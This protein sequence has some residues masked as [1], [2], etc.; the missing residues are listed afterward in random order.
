MKIE[1]PN[2][3]RCGSCSW[4][5]IPYPKQLEQKLS[6]INGSFRLKNLE[7]ECKEIIPA[8]KT[9]H[10]RN[11][12]D[13]VINF[14]GLVGLREKGRWWKVIDNHTCF[15]ADAEIERVFH[16]VRNWVQSGRLSYFDRK[17]HT[18]FL[19]YAV[20]RATSLGQS[21]LNIVSSA[22]ESDQERI[23]LEAFGAN[24]DVSTFIWSVNR[25]IQDISEGEIEQVIKGPG[26]IQE[27][28]LDTQ[29]QISPNAFFQT[30]S[31]AASNLLRTVLE[32]SEALNPNSILDLYCGG[33][34]FSVALAKQL[35]PTANAGPKARR[36]VGVELVEQAIKDARQ[37]ASLNGVD[38]EYHA[39]KTEQFSWASH[40]FELIIL[41]PPRSG[42]HD[43][44]L[45]EIL[46]VQPETI[47]YVSC[48]YKSLARELVQLKEVYSV[49]S[50][51]A[52]DMF[53][54]TPH[55]E[56]VAL[57]RKK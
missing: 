47:I 17:K 18:G 51:K 48:N 42:M 11:R 7:F 3:E 33:G 12:M 55:V 57:L 1:C 21:M 14:E 20:I 13:F 8:P 23:E 27:R 10:Y 5:H 50:L 24:L 32:H 16:E 52:I 41:D 45:K 36:I 34:F 46:R 29:Y 30:N 2:K 43:D 26:Y 31:S 22:P 19:R 44:A 40:G 28:I 9:N 54:H 56:V 15:I 39:I 37:N 49:E 53:P 38:V 6:D 4:S 25:T 35:K